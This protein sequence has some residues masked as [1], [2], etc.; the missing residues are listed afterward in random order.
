MVTFTHRDIGYT[1]ISRFE[2]AFRLFLMDKLLEQDNYL[3]FIPH[4]VL[5]LSAGRGGDREDLLSLLEHMN[6]SNLSDIVVYRASFAEYF[7]EGSF[8]Q[9]EFLELMRRLYD[10]RN[11]IAHIR[12]P[13]TALDV[14]TLVDLSQRVANWLGRDGKEF[15][16]F[17][18]DLK[19][20]PNHFVV[21]V[22]SEFIINS[23][24]SAIPNNI[25]V[26]EYELEGGFVGR[27][28]DKRRI[29]RFLDSGYH[30]VVT[31][32][33]AGGVGKTALVLNLVKEMAQQ[34]KPRFDGIVWVSAKETRLSYT[35]IEEIE[36]TLRNYEELLDAIITVMGVENAQGIGVK[37][38]EGILEQILQ[39]WEKIL[40]VIDN[41]ETIHDRRIIDFIL[42]AP[43]QLQIL[44]TS[45]RGLG[46]VE[47]RYELKQMKRKEAIRLFRKVA[48][49]KGL[50]TL[51]KQDDEVIGR[52]VDKV[53][54][55][56][57]AIKWM[58]GQVALG[59]DINKVVAEVHEASS[60]IS[61]FS[62]EQIYRSLKPASKKVLG[63]LSLLEE[64]PSVGVLQ[65]IVDM[66]RDNFEDAIRELTLVSLIIP[67]TY[68]DQRGELTTR[69][70]I[71]PLTRGYVQ[72]Q[73]SNELGLKHA[74]VQRLQEVQSV[75]EE[76]E[77]AER[78]Y[79]YSLANLGAV[80]DEEKVAAM[81]A[82]TAFQK[83]QM[84]RYV[85]AVADYQRAVKIAPRFAS[86]YRN[87]AVMEAEEG[88]LAEAEGLME[89]AVK[90]S[91]DDVSLWLTWGNIKRK[92]NRVKE[93]LYKYRKAFD[94]EP[95]NPIVLNALGQAKSR[96]GLYEEAAR[97]FERALEIS[98]ESEAED[99]RS[100]RNQIINLSSQA[101]NLLRW[102]ESLGKQRDYPAQ[103]EKLLSAWE[104][105][106]ELIKLDPND[107]KSQD[108]W[109]RT[110]LSLGYFYKHQRQENKSLFYF[111]KVVQGV[112]KPQTKFSEARD[113]LIAAIQSAQIL[114]RWG[115]VEEARHMMDRSP[116]KNARSLL[117]GRTTTLRQYY[118]LMDRLDE[119]RIRGKIIRI[120][121]RRNFVIIESLLSPGMTYLGH[122]SD[123][124]EELEISSEIYDAVV[125]FLPREPQPGKRKAVQ[126]MMEENT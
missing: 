34:E 78:Q 97:L 61:R 63:A 102:A 33:G 23:P 43:P 26:A 35:G 96:L 56:P 67:E 17:V 79:R 69:Y 13:F 46:Q 82:Q 80:T 60:D 83:Y 66:E 38:K 11:K 10:L 50:S 65:Y 37:A 101:D 27:R 42:D 4:R 59:R 74:L 107:K 113:A 54:C 44:I 40:V 52:Y 99:W 125:S 118:Q 5:E 117:R 8:S 25:P 64:S 95:S 111:K 94:L 81:L 41:L 36:P 73:L 119:N 98:L 103:E 105:C 84:G 126:V 20:F 68:K 32:S 75:I 49:E 86:L 14:E 47:R 88:H 45:R 76:A 1:V 110:L 16:Q 62:F 51:A 121:P 29:R 93:S 77:R 85:D 18:N 30:R 109:R 19:S 24:I 58:I 15:Q 9:Q 55:F 31:I 2:N 87:W 90:I 124:V 3:E 70:G 39:N 106:G 120:E 123:F 7:S 72:R 21:K 57:L 48:G 22:P 122:I 71:L 115:M 28:D 112:Q 91:S 104:I 100:R 116:S 114:I 53:S 12:E 92:G 6:F 108:L 89:E